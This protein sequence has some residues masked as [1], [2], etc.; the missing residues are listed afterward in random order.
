L[1]EVFRHEAGHSQLDGDEA[2]KVSVT[3]VKKCKK[4]GKWPQERQH[5]QSPAISVKYRILSGVF[6]QAYPLFDIIH[7]DNFPDFLL[8]KEKGASKN[9]G[10]KA[11]D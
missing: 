4:T 2:G 10:I 8:S 1:Y 9:P 11:C 6:A 7:R 5:H 3:A